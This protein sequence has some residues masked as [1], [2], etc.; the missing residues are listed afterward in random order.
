MNTEKFIN[1][2]ASILGIIGF[3]G[4]IVSVLLGNT[5]AAIVLIGLTLLI[6]M[7]WVTAKVLSLNDQ[8]QKIAPNDQA[9]AKGNS[10]NMGY[11]IEKHLENAPLIT[12]KEQKHEKINSNFLNYDECTILINVLVPNENTGLR[13][14]KTQRYILGHRETVNGKEINKFALRYSSNKKWEV[15]F[16]NAMDNLCSMERTDGLRPGWHQFMITWDKSQPQLD[17]RIDQG[18]RETSITFLENWP[19]HLAETVCVG[20][21]K[22]SDDDSFAEAKLADLWIINKYMGSNAQDVI[23]H[24]RLRTSV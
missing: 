13:N 15:I 6:W 4:T 23:E 14:T 1:N 9:R 17:F 7:A 20:A 2:S 11:Q 24:R 10:H 22:S 21:W 19:E 3:V 12:C 18:S 16:S 5:M 8:L